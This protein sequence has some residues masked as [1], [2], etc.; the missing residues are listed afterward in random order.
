MRE[1]RGQIDHAGPFDRRRLQGGDL[2]LAQESG[3]RWL[4]WAESELAETSGRGTRKPCSCRRS[5][6][7]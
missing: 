3:P 1:H 2:V 7:I 6:T 5:T 4:R